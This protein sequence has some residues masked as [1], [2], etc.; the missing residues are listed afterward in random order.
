MLHQ[1]KPLLQ[2]HRKRYFARGF[3]VDQSESVTGSGSPGTLGG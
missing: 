3:D 2:D 1:L